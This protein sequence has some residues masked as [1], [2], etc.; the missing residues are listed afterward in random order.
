MK[1]EVSQETANG[2]AVKTAHQ[3]Y[4][5]P[6]V[7]EIG[8]TSDIVQSYYPY[9]YSEDGYAGYYVYKMY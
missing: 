7:F 8:R 6:M 5:Q 9:N 2:D 3:S 1:L 4:V